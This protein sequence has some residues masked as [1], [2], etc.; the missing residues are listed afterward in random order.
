VVLGPP[1]L[2]TVRQAVLVAVLEYLEAVLLMPQGVVFL[3][4]VT[5][6]V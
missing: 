2:I 5:L 6:E 1:V 4:K 3:V